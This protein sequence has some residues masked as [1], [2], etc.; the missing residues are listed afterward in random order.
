MST[1]VIYPHPI[2]RQIV[3]RCHVGEDYLSVVRYVLSKLKGGRT[4]FFTV[5][6]DERRYIIGST[7]ACH[8]E[9]RNTY[10]AVM[11]GGYLDA[12]DIIRRTLARDVSPDTDV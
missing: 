5:P 8:A 1:K 2:V 12:W 6:R 3:G 9:N 4:A 10:S 11:G 7:L